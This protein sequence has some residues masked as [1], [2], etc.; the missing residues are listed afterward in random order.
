MTLYESVNL[1]FVLDIP[2]PTHDSLIAEK[3]RH[4]RLQTELKLK[5]QELAALM[6]RVKRNTVSYITPTQFIKITQQFGL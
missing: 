5:Q 4:R 3:L 1:V 2:T 6:D